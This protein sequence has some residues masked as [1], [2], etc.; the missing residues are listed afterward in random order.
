MSARPR[1]EALARA[2]GILPGWRSGEGRLHVPSDATR[3]ALLEAMGF[4]AS[5]ESAAAHAQA[6]FAER[7]HARLLS[8]AAVTRRGDPLRLR[9][10]RPTSEASQAALFHVSIADEAGDRREIEGQIE[11]GTTAI[12]LPPDLGIGDYDVELVVSSGA[13]RRRGRQRRVVAPPCC[14][15]LADRIGPSR[16][17]G[18]FAQ[19]YE[20]RSRRDWGIGDLGDVARLT[21]DAAAAGVDFVALSPVH[22]LANREPGASP[23]SPLSR[24]FR[25]PIHLDLEAIPELAACAGARA[26]L[27]DPALRASRDALRAADWLDRPAVDRLKTSVLRALH[28]CFRR[29]C[30]DPGSSRARDYARYRAR[31]GSALDD[32]A[33]FLALDEAL[34][35]THG[36]DWRRWPIA[37]HDAR[38]GA[39]ARFRDA[40]PETIDFHRYLQF[41]LDRQHAACADAARASGMRIGLVADLALGSSPTGADAWLL[42]ELLAEAASIGAPPDAFNPSGQDWDMRPVDPHRLRAHAFRP[43]T[44]LLRSAMRHAGGLRIDHAMSMARLFWIPRGRPPAEGAY[45]AYPESEL[46]GL[47]AFESQRAG[48]IVIGEDLGTV[49]PGFDRLLESFEIL[50]WQVLYFERDADGFR[51]ASAYSRRALVSANTHDLPPLAGY[52]RGRDLEIRRAAG[53][54][55]DDA[56]LAT[57]SRE[58]TATCEALAHRLVEEG[59]LAPGEPLPPPPRLTAI[60]HAFLARTPAPLVGVSL[61]DLA[62]ESEPV[63]MPGLRADQYPSWRRRLSLLVEDVAAKLSERASPTTGADPPAQTQSPTAS[64]RAE[65][66]GRHV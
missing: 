23:Y 54:L 46:L 18:L 2:V 8:P 24:R 15:P 12:E 30:A 11:P 7:T 28:G 56:E 42:P 26:L 9:L 3:E 51:P 62:D 52:V 48:A 17:L 66:E 60:V 34:A 31:E 29:V 38:S 50:S 53:L 14:A 40:H 59:L 27:S 39:V 10:H 4:D 49:P 35:P 65:T 20:L 37:Y 43:W 55:A 58:R 41:E 63:N 1:L 44:D 19:L 32:F 61:A 36:P 47:L 22:A 45:V 33:T 16:A 21:R 5:S 6:R 57:A 64:P 25:N 13:V